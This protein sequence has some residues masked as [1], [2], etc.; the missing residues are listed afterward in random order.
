MIMPTSSLNMERDTPRREIVAYSRY[1]K[2]RWVFDSFYTSLHQALHVHR[3]L[4]LGHS[5]H[6]NFVHFWGHHRFGRKD[7]V[8]WPYPDATG[9]WWV[10]CIGI[11]IKLGF[12]TRV[13]LG[14]FAAISQ[15]CWLYVGFFFIDGFLS[16]FYKSKGPNWYSYLLTWLQYPCILFEDVAKQTRT[17]L[18]LGMLP[19]G[20]TWC[21]LKVCARLEPTSEKIGTCSAAKGWIFIWIWERLCFGSRLRWNWRSAG[22]N[23]KT[24]DIYI[25]N[26]IHLF[27]CIP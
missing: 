22:S 17:S 23:S 16:D 9:W 10:W 13:D 18:V 19:Q 11:G 5:L 1:T 20:T 4:P 8:S 26:I 21:L 14:T 2:M 12:I 7:V 27:C 15:F 6:N 25:R 3:A 24:F